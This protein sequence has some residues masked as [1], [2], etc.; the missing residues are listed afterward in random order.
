MSKTAALSFFGGVGKIGGNCILLEAGSTLVLFDVGKDFQLYRRYFDFPLNLPSRSVGLELVKTGILPVVTTSDGRPL[1]LYVEKAGDQ[2]LEPKEKNRLDAV[3]LSHAHMDHAGF[4]SVL[5]SDITIRS[6]ALAHTILQ[7]SME[8]RRET[9]LES[10]TYWKEESPHVRRPRLQFS[11]FRSG[12]VEKVDG[13]EVRPCAVD[14]SVPGSYGFIA[15]AGGQ[16]ICY[17]GDF[18]FHGPAGK[19]S[20][21]FM[22]RLEADRPDVLICEGTN[23]NSGRT[24]TEARVEEDATSLIQGSFGAGTRLAVAEVKSTDL[25]RILG[26]VEAAK[27]VGCK[28][29]F[30]TRL[31]YL[32]KR[33]LDAR[34]ESRLMQRLPRFGRDFFVLLRGKKRLEWWEKALVQDPSLTFEPSEAL[35]DPRENLLVVDS[36]RF[37]VF[38]VRP[39]P[40]TLYIQ[41]VSEHIDEEGE[42]GEERF[43]NALA[44]HGVVTYRL[45]SSG[46]C[47]PLDLIRFI[48]AVAPKKLIPIHT[49]HPEAF[50]EI[51]KG[52]TEVVLPSKGVPVKL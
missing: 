41:S 4:V 46:H 7:S 6:G 3:F 14:H 49:E 45:H 38:E 28:L 8:T 48:D 25:D 5:R 43:L 18:R 29:L 51:F 50:A 11:F 30:T 36:G 33:I 42:F 34:L 2:I 10:F 35:R 1:N 21:G 15:D 40:R 9:S 31:T 39:P 17:T 52:K 20:E 13:L 26:F 19:L 23:I 22:H 27:K 37:N 12:K 24:E 47:N 32:F 44:L 16:R